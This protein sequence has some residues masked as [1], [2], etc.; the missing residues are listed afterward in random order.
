M[1]IYSALITLALLFPNFAIAEDVKSKAA[2]EQFLN[3][4]AEEIASGN[5]QNVKN[6]ISKELVTS[7]N[8]QLKN[9]NKII[10]KNEKINIHGMRNIGSIYVVNSSLGGALLK[11]LVLS[12]EGSDLQIV[13][14]VG[15]AQKYNIQNNDSIALTVTCTQDVQRTIAAHSEGQMPCQED[16]ICWWFSGTTFQLNGEVKS[17]SYMSTSHIDA[18]INKEGVL[19]CTSAC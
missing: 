18:T 15:S 16:G 7:F 13:G 6:Y 12:D 19:S 14:M 17:C 3:Q 5:I 1:K 9:T 11:T 4:I 8:S 10:N 2:I